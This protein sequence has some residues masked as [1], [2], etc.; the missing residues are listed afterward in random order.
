MMLPRDK[1]LI[2]PVLDEGEVKA[3]KREKN[4]IMT[5]RNM[6]HLLRMYLTEF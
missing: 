6:G 1:A 5:E 2:G 3:G 4:K